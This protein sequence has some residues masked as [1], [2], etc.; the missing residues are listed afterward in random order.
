MIRVLEHAAGGVGASPQAAALAG[1]VVLVAGAA[2]GLGRASAL[3]CAKAGAT[4]VLL[5]RTVRALE[6]VYDGIE[7]VGGARPAIYPLDLAGAS[8]RDHAELAD[9]IVAQ[10]GRLDGLVHAAAHFSG[11]QPFDEQA[12]EEWLRCLHVNATAP[13]LLTQACL[14]ALRERDDAAVVFVLDD[15]ARVG[16]AF[17]GGYGAAKHAVAGLASIVH[18]ETETGPVRTHALLPAP[19]RTRLRREAYFGEDTLGIEPPDRA[20]EAVAWLLTP[21]AREWRGRVLDLRPPSTA[22][23]QGD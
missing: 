7:A 5:G 1:R 2:G 21:Q 17:W 16:K 18:E 11:L 3:A 19:M 6:K 14:P 12:P 15:P 8:P 20:G 9:A 22:T 4:V 10:C 13:Y 23:G